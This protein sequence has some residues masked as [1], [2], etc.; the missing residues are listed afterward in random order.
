MTFLTFRMFVH[1]LLVCF[2]LHW[3]FVAESRLSVVGAIGG[4]SSSRCTGFS[5]QW[6]LLLRCVG[7]RLLGEAYGLQ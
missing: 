3:V 1:C 7:S 5:L 2:W 6:L 4:S